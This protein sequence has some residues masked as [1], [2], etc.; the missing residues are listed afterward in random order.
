MEILTKCQSESCVDGCDM[1]WYECA[2]QRLQL[3]SIKP[4]V[5]ADDM[6][7]LLTYERD[8]F[9]NVLIVGPANRGQQIYAWVGA[10]QAEVTVLQDF[11]W[12]SEL[13]W[14]K[15]LLHFLEGENVKLSSPKNHIAT[16]ICINTDLLIF[17]TSKG[18]IEFVRKQNTHDRK[19]EIMDS[20]WNRFEFTDRI[21]QADY[22]YLSQ[23][24]YWTSIT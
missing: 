1:E 23:M 24:L 19:T 21:P 5:F 20:W 2:R 15:D 3:N 17:A 9:R 13:I 16:D 14:W 7:D 11:R 10:D 18:K 4:F 22:S 8:K 6:S 12:G